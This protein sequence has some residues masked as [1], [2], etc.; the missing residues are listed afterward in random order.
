MVN[1]N[2]ELIT[3]LGDVSIRLNDKISGK[4]KQL[5][6]YSA[7]KYGSLLNE[8][9]M[10]DYKI[11]DYSVTLFF[12]KTRFQ[13]EKHLLDQVVSLFQESSINYRVLKF[14]QNQIIN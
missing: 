1:M 8:E 13:F 5:D 14:I 12:A 11:T 3:Y 10:T 7:K 2:Y 9:S 4:R 6:Q